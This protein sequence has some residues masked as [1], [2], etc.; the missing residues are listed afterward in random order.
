MSE[1]T[2]QAE[3]IKVK[4]GQKSLLHNINLAIPTGQF[5]ALV[6][7]NGAGKSTLLKL[8]SGL[9][10][11]EKGDIKLAGRLLKKMTSAEIAE[12]LSYLPQRSEIYWDYRVS[13]ILELHADSSVF[14]A[15]FLQEFD[16]ENLLDRQFKTLSGG[17]QAR[18]LLAASLI[19]HPAILLADEPAAALDV[20]HQLQLLKRIKDRTAEGLTAIV[21]MHDLNLATRFADRIV[22]LNNGEIQLDDAT[23]SVIMSPALDLHFD[24]YF[25]RL[26]MDLQTILIPHFHSEK[27][28]RENAFL[29]AV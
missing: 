24:V 12:Q 10:R 27:P 13:D 18:V 3:G 5:V 23:Q 28:A 7:P 17:E 14:A 2:I 29:K 26:T 11:P 1:F 20:A 16:I 15:A 25:Q 22:V 19:S 8:L 4:V 21:V 9:N 6:G